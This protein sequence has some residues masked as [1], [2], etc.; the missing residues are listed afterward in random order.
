MPL[1]VVILFYLPKYSRYFLKKSA[2]VLNFYLLLFTAISW[3]RDCVVTL[4][5]DFP[6]FP[7]E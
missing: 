1:I 6:D 2:D 5:A 4:P 3:K 7:L